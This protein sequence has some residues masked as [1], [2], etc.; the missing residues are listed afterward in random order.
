MNTLTKFYEDH[1]DQ[2][3][4]FC[5]WRVRNKSD[6]EDLTAEAF[7]RFVRQNGLNREYPKAYLY[8]ICRNLIIDH[9]R[10][11]KSVTSLDSLLD[12]GFEPETI[13]NL[14]QLAE[15]NLVYKNVELLTDDQ[16]EAITLRYQ[17]DLDMKTIGRIM[18]KSEAAVKNLIAR[19]LV[20]LQEKLNI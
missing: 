19:G 17:Q 14:E 10:T 20:Q 18:E 9:Y 4:N 8:A 16:R 1:A 6:A 11:R 5:Y 13:S 7:L 3:Y 12:S 2:I 15:L